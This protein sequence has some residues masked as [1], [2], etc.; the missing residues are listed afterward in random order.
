MKKVIKSRAF[1]GVLE[2]FQFSSPN[3]GCRLFYGLQNFGQNVFFFAKIE[4]LGAS[5]KFLIQFLLNL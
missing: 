2:I 4:G 1:F 3:W 5:A